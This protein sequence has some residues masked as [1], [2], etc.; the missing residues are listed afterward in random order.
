MMTFEGSD[1]EDTSSCSD[2]S[3]DDDDDFDDAGKSVPCTGSSKPAMVIPYSQRADNCRWDYHMVLLLE[4][5]DLVLRLKKKRRTN[6]LLGMV[7]H[8]QILG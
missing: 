2:S 7:F 8:S 3:D 4:Q 6:M 5:W 1:E